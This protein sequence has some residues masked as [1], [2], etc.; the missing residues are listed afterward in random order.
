MRTL[1]VQ[2]QLSVEEATTFVGLRA[3]HSEPTR[4]LRLA[5]GEPGVILTEDGA[6]LLAIG[7]LD[8]RL[9]DALHTVIPTVEWTTTLRG[10]TG[11]RNVSKTFGWA[12]RKVYMERESCRSTELMHKQPMIGSL[13]VS[14]ADWCGRWMAAELPEVVEH[15]RETLKPVLPEWRLDEGDADLWT[16][17]VIN[18]DSPM[19]YHRDGSNFPTWS[20][21]PVIRRGMAGGYLHLPEH[22]L[23]VPCAD[24]TVVF[25]WGQR[26]VHGVTPMRARGKGSYR[27]TVV[28]YAIR[29]MKDCATFARELDTGRVRRTAR[30]Q[31][32]ADH[33]LATGTAPSP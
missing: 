22:D 18:K 7:R 5:A 24:G 14:V 11:Y 31:A 10:Q 15:D 3:A 20:A 30:E 16:S 26:L 19:P 9:A 2:R 8:P 29:G 33:I 28:Y 23:T 32:V 1:P 25:F 21:M 13:L 27:F 4:E 12:H 17:G 6:P